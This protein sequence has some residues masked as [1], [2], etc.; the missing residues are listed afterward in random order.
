MPRGTY[1]RKVDMNQREIVLTLR[2]CGASVFSL[3]SMGEG[4]PDLLVGIFGLSAI[5]EV[6]DGSKPPSAQKLT[7]AQQKF[8]RSWKGDY[9]ILRSKED[10]LKLVGAMR[11]RASSIRRGQ[12][13]DTEVVNE[14]K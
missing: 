11:L 4:C 14:P 6:K 9:H 2:Q 10:A 13:N 12:L 5:A 8:V 3:A 7:N 1:G